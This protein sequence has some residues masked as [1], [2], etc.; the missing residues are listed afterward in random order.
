M[1]C[2]PALRT[3]GCP[4]RSCASTRCR[5]RRPAR[6]INSGCAPSMGKSMR[7]KAGVLASLFDLTGRVAI[8]TGGSRGLGLQIASAL[9]EFGASLALVARK[10]PD[11]DAAVEQLRSAGCA[12]VG[13]VADLGT[14]EAASDLAAQVIE[15]FGRI[16]ILVNNAGTVWGAP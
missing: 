3:G 6:S 11:L 15:R 5:S 14:P 8:V 16:D 9:G 4:M 12:A 2:E 13:F 7:P 10:K 1:R